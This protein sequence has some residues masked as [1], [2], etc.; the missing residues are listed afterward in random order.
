MLFKIAATE[1]VQLHP[2]DFHARYEEAII[3]ILQKRL[4][5]KISYKYGTVLAI[6]HLTD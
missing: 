1:T 6:R 4:Y 5:N 3:Q 2:A